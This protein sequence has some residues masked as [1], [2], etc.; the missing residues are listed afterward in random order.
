[1]RADGFELVAIPMG[2]LTGRLAELDA[3]QAEGRMAIVIGGTGLYFSALTKGLTDIPPV[4]GEVRASR[5]IQSACVPLV[6]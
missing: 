1:M 6:M 2:Q 5:Q 3:A 4:P